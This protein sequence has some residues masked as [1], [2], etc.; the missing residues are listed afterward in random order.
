LIGKVPLGQYRIE[1]KLGEGGFGAVYLAEQL[2]VDRKAVIKVV[3]QRLVQDEVFVKRFQREAKVLAMLDQHHLVK[4]YNF[5]ALDSGELFLA[6]EY[7]GDR[8]LQA[9]LKQHGRLPLARALRIAAQIAEALAEAHARG[10]IHRDLKPPNVLLGD[11]DGD[12]WA[13]V[14][15]VGI[16]KILEQAGAGEAEEPERITGLTGGGV[17]GTPAYFSPEQAQGLPLDGRSDLYSLGI[18]LYEM[19]TGVLPIRGKTTTD[20]IRAHCVDEPLAPE[21]VGVALPRGV[22]K[23]LR[24]LLAKEPAG[25]LQSA[26]ELVEALELL[27]DE[28]LGPKRRTGLWLGLG[29]A[30][31]VGCVG[32]WLAT[33]DPA[34]GPSAGADAMRAPAAS[35]SSLAP[36]EPVPAPTAPP[37]PAP[38]PEPEAATAPVAPR[39]Q[40]K[41]PA[42]EPAGPASGPHLAPPPVAPPASGEASP[43]T[44]ACKS[45]N[46]RLT[47]TDPAATAVSPRGGAVRF[48]SALGEWELEA[49]YSPVP[50]GLDVLLQTTPPSVA[51]RG[52]RPLGPTARL[53]LGA[54]PVQLDFS[55]SE[56]SEPLVVVC[57]FTAA[58]GAP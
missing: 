38:E 29:V 7:G 8:T 19:L 5:G 42:Q 26:A 23:L 43:G 27:R 28:A 34:V 4:L 30:L 20:F 37:A 41:R 55:S 24:K 32:V 16:A 58:G 22:K 56:R 45:F 53:H 2:N 13:K 36:S 25:R 21:K 6:M 1:R 12:D 31:L 48:R 14:V 40:R 33:R 54:D 44:L 49:R 46:S 18:V 17:I 11:K 51:I 3:H 35:A 10:I 47:P 50:G 9:E 57:S 52:K 15:D 39:G